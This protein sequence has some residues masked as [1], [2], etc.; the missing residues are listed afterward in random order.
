MLFGSVVFCIDCRR[1]ELRLARRGH[2]SIFIC[3]V[4]TV[5]GCVYLLTAVACGAFEGQII[6][7]L[8][9]AGLALP[10]VSS[11]DSD[12]LW[13]ISLL[14]SWGSSVN[15]PSCSWPGRPSR[16]L[17]K[18]RTG[19]AWRCGRC[20]LH[21]WCPTHSSAPDPRIAAWSSRSRSSTLCFAEGGR[22]KS[23][24]A[25]FPHHQADIGAAAHYRASS[26]V[27]GD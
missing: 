14:L 16:G 3:I 18:R 27:S 6:T 25:Q 8:L 17:W 1:D 13:G 21:H 9:T 11:K 5:E 10:R 23:N 2:A 12:V 26:R 24:L 7:I 19:A 15:A 4:S 22:R 20:A